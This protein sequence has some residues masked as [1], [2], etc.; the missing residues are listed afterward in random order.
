MRTGEAVWLK[1]SPWAALPAALGVFRQGNL[2]QALP[3]LVP[4]VVLVANV[5]AIGLQEVGL[6]VVALLAAL[7]AYAVVWQQRFRYRVDDDGIAV[8]RGVLQRSEVALSWERV[9]NVDLRQP[10]YFRPLDRVAL[11]VEGSGGSDEEV[12]I[13]AVP[14]EVA[15]QVRESI[16]SYR[17]A[18]A[19]GRGAATAGAAASPLDATGEAG[20]GVVVG[21]MSGD[22]GTAVGTV[23]DDGDVVG[24]EEPVVL[25]QPTTGEILLHGAINGRAFALLLA[26]L[27]AV[28]TA[29]QPVME[30]TD[31][32]VGVVDRVIAW[33]TTALILALPGLVVL[34]VVLVVVSA[35]IAFVRFH[36]FQ[37]WR[38]HDR[39]RL[40]HGL[41]ETRE[42]TL[43]TSKLQAVTVVETA[44]GR[45]LGRC[46]VLAHQASSASQEQGATSDGTAEIPALTSATVPSVVARFD[47]SYGERPPLAQVDPAFKRFW[48]SRSVVLL[49]L[50]LTAAL[51][52]LAIWGDAA[53]WLLVVLSVLLLA[54]AGLSVWLVRVRWRHWG[55]ATDGEVVHIASGLLGRQ[56]E[57]FRLDRVQ[58]VN[59]RRT[60]FQRRHGL[61]NL[62]LGLADG[63]RQVPFLRDDDAVA[64]ANLA[65]FTV[66]TRPHRDL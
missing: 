29:L 20:A 48:A 38:D 32:I 34:S 45:L 46:H 39:F 54:L 60:P 3:G 56:W 35:L 41:L 18:Q 9:R 42:R 44:V 63:D 7:A 14:R 17:R 21:E 31:L 43:R 58:Q 37:L 24:A 11:I 52:A 26:G 30:E 4:V 13:Q 19:P 33:G 65:L 22:R 28:F 5:D 55:W 40:R 27:G 66:E 2:L 10:F 49:V 16:V 53:V 6:G 51:A 8:Q 61:A 12:A 57:T 1:L 59:V 25:H 47:P 62:M 50:P 36:D 15:E 64:F 23:L